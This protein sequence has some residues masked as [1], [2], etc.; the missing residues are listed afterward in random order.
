MKF[1]FRQILGFQCAICGDLLD[2]EEEQERALRVL[3]RAAE[4]EAYELKGAELMF[5]FCPSCLSPASNPSDREW[6]GAVTRYNMK[7]RAKLRER[8]NA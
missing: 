4:I 2:Q 6:R 1:G 8:S 3:A 5:E 7:K